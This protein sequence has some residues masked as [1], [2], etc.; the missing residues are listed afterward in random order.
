MANNTKIKEIAL[1]NAK[2]SIK[3]YFLTFVI[4]KDYKIVW[5]DGELNG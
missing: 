3:K 1:K 5:K 2:S 4:D